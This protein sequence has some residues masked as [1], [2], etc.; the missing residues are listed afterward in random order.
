[1]QKMRD[2]FHRHRFTPFVFISGPPRFLTSTQQPS[3]RVSLRR[4]MLPEPVVERPNR[5]GPA[6]GPLAIMALVLACWSPSE[7]AGALPFDGLAT[8]AATMA[9]SHQSLLLPDGY[10]PGALWLRDD[11]RGRLRNALIE[12]ARRRNGRKM[13][14]RLVDSGFITVLAS[15]PLNPYQAGLWGP[16][17]FYGRAVGAAIHVDLTQILA[18]DYDPSGVE[19]LAHELRHQV[20]AARAFGKGSKYGSIYR[21]ALMGD[22]TRS[23]HRY[24]RRI[25]LQPPDLTAAEA[26]RWIEP[27]LVPT[28]S[29]PGFR[30]ASTPVR[31]AGRP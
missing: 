21:A 5:P 19:T 3:A 25:R 4:K 7:R 6:S 16:I 2:A 18:L 27:M 24:G 15:T 11:S 1:M 22:R 13:V 8:L 20:D 12:L 9:D 29:T 23:A 31:I 28:D 10:R 14:Q 17:F 26:H 30:R